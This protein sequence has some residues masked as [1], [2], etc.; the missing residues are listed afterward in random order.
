VG[1]SQNP[2]GFFRRPTDAVQGPGWPPCAQSRDADGRG[3][4]APLEGTCHETHEHT[5]PASPSSAKT[6]PKSSELPC[7]PKR[8][9][10]QCPHPRKVTQPTTRRFYKGPGNFRHR[11][12]NPTPEGRMPGRRRTAKT[13]VLPTRTATPR[14][15]D[16]SEH[17][18]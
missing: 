5:S 11:F 18:L 1:H 15:T 7:S 9:P 4:R 13:E 3:A 12:L 14:G 17:C 6:F 2:E 16:S 8:E 10:L